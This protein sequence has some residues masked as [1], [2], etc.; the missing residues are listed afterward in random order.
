MSETEPR[1]KALDHYTEPPPHA[2]LHLCS[3]DNYC[4]CSVARSCPTLCDP[5]IAARQASLTFAISWSLLKLIST[6]SVMSSNHLI[7]CLPLLLLPSIFPS[8]RVFSSE[9]ALHIRCPKYCS[10]S[11]IISP[12][13]VLSGLISFRIE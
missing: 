8:I 13:N 6:E 7:L 10:F 5:L 1:P 4:G 2:T 11:F 12:S 9:S 3:P